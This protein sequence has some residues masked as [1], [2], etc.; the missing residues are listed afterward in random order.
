MHL[1]KR[2]LAISRDEFGP[3][4]DCRDLLSVVRVPLL[5]F[6]QDPDLD[7]ARVAVLGDGPDDLDSY[8]LVR[9]GVDGLDNLAEGPLTQK[10]DSPVFAG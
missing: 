2:V 7:L 8:P 5:E 10:A 4:P 6:L 3:L 1:L 9:L